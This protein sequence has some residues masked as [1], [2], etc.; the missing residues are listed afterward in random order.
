MNKLDPNIS[1][2]HS[3]N[4]LAGSLDHIFASAEL[5]NHVTGI[6]VWHIN[7]DEPRVMDYN[8]EFQTPGQIIEW[9]SP[10]AF[11]SSDH[12]PVIT[13]ICEGTPPAVTVT[14]DPDSLW[15]PNHQYVDVTATVEVDDFDSN[16]TITLVSVTSNEADNGLGDG[17]TPNDIVIVDDFNFQLRAER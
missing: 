2:T 14:L 16:P 4:G 13:G 15:P 3:Y 10:E 6:T 11:R 17:D 1:Y 5:A 9:Y 12:D 7:A 8:V